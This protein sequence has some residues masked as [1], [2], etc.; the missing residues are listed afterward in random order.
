MLLPKDPHEELPAGVQWKLVDFGVGCRAVS[1]RRAD[2]EADETLMHRI[3]C[4]RCN[5]EL[6]LPPRLKRRGLSDKEKI[7]CPA[8]G[9]VFIGQ[10]EQPGG[11]AGAKNSPSAAGNGEEASIGGTVGYMAPELEAIDKAI[12]KGAPISADQAA[13]LSSTAL[14]LF[15]LGRVLSFC[16]TGVHPNSNPTFEKLEKSTLGILRRPSFERRP[17]GKAVQRRKT[18][19]VPAR[20]LL[21]ALTAEDPT[22]RPAV[23]SVAIQEWLKMMEDVEAPKLLSGEILGR[24]HSMAPP[25]LV[26]K[27][28]NGSNGSSQ[29]ET[30]DCVVRHVEINLVSSAEVDVS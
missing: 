12:R 16:L 26:E 19:S 1:H 8:C 6:F 11:G 10:F 7:K 4:S 28:S 5:K 20:A 21:A 30:E 25:K 2:A 22:E 17:K 27:F 3:A 18:L 23:N 9:H 15:S 14:D 24:N 13:G 29:G